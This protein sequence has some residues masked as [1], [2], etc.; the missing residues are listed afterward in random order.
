MVFEEIDD[1]ILP[2]LDSINFFNS[3]LEKFAKTPDI[4]KDFPTKID[5]T[6]LFESSI[7]N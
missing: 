2:P 7:S 3:S 5:E 4:T 6:F 1:D